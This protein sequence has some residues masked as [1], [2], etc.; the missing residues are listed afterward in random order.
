M[1]ELEHVTKTFRLQGAVKI[2]M[3]DVSMTFPRGRSVGLL[4]R[5]GSGKSTLLRMIAGASDPDSGR[6]HRLGRLS[7]PLG[8]SGGFH[9]SLTGAQNARF[10]ARIYGIDT[11]DMIAK[12]EDFAE[13]G[14]FLHERVETY[15]SG[16]KARLAFGVSMAVDF[17]VYLVDEITAVGDSAFRRKCLQAFEDKRAKADVIM[18]SHSPGMIREYCDSGVVLEHGTLAY[19]ADI[20][21]ALAAHEENMRRA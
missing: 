13:L 18:V 19:F 20:D 17:D 11:D 15:S 9:P 21:D 16:M 10:V 5:N 6:I 14:P 1:I 3:N 7:W 8:F 4:G 2:I 12:V